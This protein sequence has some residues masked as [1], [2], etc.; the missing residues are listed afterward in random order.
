[1]MRTILQTIHKKGLF[2]DAIFLRRFVKGLWVFI[3][4]T[5]ASYLY[6]VG[7]ITFSIIERQGLQQGIREIV[8]TISAKELTYLSI[9]RSLTKSEGILLGLSEAK[10]ITFS[11]RTIGTGFAFNGNR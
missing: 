8:S 7:A 4:V 3:G 10:T 6:F 5:F 9:D 2:S 11:A 1:M